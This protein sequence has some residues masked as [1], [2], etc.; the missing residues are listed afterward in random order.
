LHPSHPTSTK[1]NIPTARTSTDGKD[2]KENVTLKLD[3]II[4]LIIVLI[5]LVIFM[6][7]FKRT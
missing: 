1:S 3:V 5:I 7:V 6:D 4:A 2:V